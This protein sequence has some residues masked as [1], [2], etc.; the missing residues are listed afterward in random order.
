MQL[1]AAGEKDAHVTVDPS[2]EVTLSPPPARVFKGTITYDDTHQPVADARVEIGA[3]LEVPSRCIMNMAGRTDAGGHFRLN[4]YS[5]KIFFISVHP[6]E[7]T[8]YLSY[9]KEIKLSDGQ[10]PPRI[11]IAL[12][13]GVLLRGKITEK[14]SGQPVARAAV[15]YEELSRK[16]YRPDRILPDHSPPH[17]R[18][19]SGADG[20]Y[21]IAV[22]PGRGVLFVQGPHNDY[23]RRTI[24]TWD[25]NNDRNWTIAE[26]H[27]VGAYASLDVRPNQESAELNLAIR[28]GVTVRGRIVGPSNQPVGDVLILSRHFLG[29]NEDTWNGGNVHVRSGQFELHGL[30]P[31]ASVPFYFLDPKNE[32]GATVDLSGKSAENGPLVVR[33]QACG[34]AVARYVTPAGKPKVKY[35]PGLQILV[36]PGPFRGDDKRNRREVSSDQD[37]VAN[38]D[39]EHYWDK[40]LTDEDGRCTFPAL[41]PGATYRIPLANKLGDWDQRDFTV[42]P[43]ETLQLPDITVPEP[44]PVKP[45]R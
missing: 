3:T 34:R 43:G 15:K 40:P 24:N 37:F 14:S 45:K 16:P 30:D 18:G 41:I 27:Y 4:P 1:G 12:P 2:G 32:L 21:Q 33:L 19:A 17:I 35:D 25:F 42:K 9:Q 39:R 6:P 31:D 5:G 29:A 7:G 26:R 10:Q 28:R 44:V 13:R 8:P 11:E 22:P 23:I 38:F 36:S 20:T